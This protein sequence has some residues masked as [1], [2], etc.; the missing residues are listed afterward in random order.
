L[1]SEVITSSAVHAFAQSFAAAHSGN[2]P[3]IIEHTTNAG[4]TFA[5]F[6]SDLLFLLGS[7][8]NLEHDRSALA[9]RA[10]E[11]NIKGSSGRASGGG[12]SAQ[13]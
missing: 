11:T 12:F 2:A 8:A 10:A 4:V 6:I 7:P 3:L 13:S 5:I 1:T 9:L